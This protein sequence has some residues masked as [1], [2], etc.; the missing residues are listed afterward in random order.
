[1]QA[2]I[3]YLNSEYDIRF[4]DNSLLIEAFTHSSY[5][6]EHRHLNLTDNERLEFLGDAVLEISVSDYLFHEYTHH[7]EGLLTRL[8]SEIVREN[9]LYHFSLDCGFDR[10]VRLGKGEE[11]NAGRK[12]PSLLADLFEAFLGSLYLDQD[13]KAVKEFLSKVVF[14]KI[15]DGVFSYG[16]DFKTKLQEYLQQDGEVSI[17]YE[18]IDSFGPAHDRF[19]VVQVLAGGEVLGQGKGRTKKQAEQMAAKDAL[20]D[21]ITNES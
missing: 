3:E 2:L 16:M 17:V 6:N 8:R 12:R 9:S 19:F 11:Q 10:Y 20:E 1:M 14:P 4:N 7:P 15:K 18:L 21:I 5:V 13:L